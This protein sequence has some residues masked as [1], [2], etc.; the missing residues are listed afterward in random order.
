MKDKAT[1]KLESLQNCLRG[2]ELRVSRRGVPHLVVKGERGTC[3]ACWFGRG[4]FFRIFYPFPEGPEG[5]EHWDAPHPSAAM[6][7]IEE[8]IG[9]V[10]RNELY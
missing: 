5:R 8:V 6:R 3:S 9:K 2:G 7:K 1:R 10:E 4:G